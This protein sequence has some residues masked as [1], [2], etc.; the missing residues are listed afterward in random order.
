[1]NLLGIV[2]IFKICLEKSYVRVN[3]ITLSIT[4][5]KH[6]IRH[7]YIGETMERTPKKYK[8]IPSNEPKTKAKLKKIG[9]LN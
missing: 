8:L 2:Q 1:M 3:I 6:K 7:R 4:G 9:L 5:L